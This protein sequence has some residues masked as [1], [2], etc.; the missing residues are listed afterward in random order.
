MHDCVQHPLD[1]SLSSPRWTQTD[2]WLWGTEPQ[3]NE[4]SSVSHKKER[5]HRPTLANQRRLS[6]LVT[7]RDPTRFDD[8]AYCVYS[9]GESSDYTGCNHRWSSKQ[10]VVQSRHKCTT[11]MVHLKCG[12]QKVTLS[13]PE[14]GTFN[15]HVELVDWPSEELGERDHHAKSH[16]LDDRRKCLG[17][18]D[19]VLLLETLRDV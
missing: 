2:L 3:E 10:Q 14:R 18:V 4:V 1:T 15:N 7:L 12:Y 5:E 11:N 19:S 16:V 6:L 8:Y 9:T 17:V 13:V